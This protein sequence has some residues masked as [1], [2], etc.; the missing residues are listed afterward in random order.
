MSS[1][2]LLWQSAVGCTRVAQATVGS[3]Q[4][5]DNRKGK[6]MGNDK[7]L[8]GINIDATVVFVEHATLERADDSTYWRRICPK[9]EVGT[10]L[11][12]REYGTFVLSLLDR[13]DK[14]GQKFIYRDIAHMRE[15]DGRA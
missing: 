11:V 6:T 5:G 8:E 12:Q 1:K 10:L 14:C 7:D 15:K 2:V 3:S 9:C 4:F 13:C